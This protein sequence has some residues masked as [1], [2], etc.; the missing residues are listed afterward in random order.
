MVGT[1]VLDPANP[2][3]VKG[4]IK[5]DLN[6]LKTGLD[7]RDAAMRSTFLQS[8]GNDANRYAVFDVRGAEIAGPL[9]PG[10]ARPAK[11]RGALTIRG[12][13][14]ETIADCVIH[15]VRLTPEQAAE[16]KIYG[17]TPDTLRVIARF[18]TTFT[19]HAMQIPQFL[20]LR[21]SNDIQLETD[22]VLVKAP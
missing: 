18:A 9:E 16:Q 15:Y 12:K 10:K 7:R 8:E 13:A 3:A 11:V 19:N 1:I 20:I 22:L 17:F 5:V 6:T 14:I 21:V 2:Q 4:Q